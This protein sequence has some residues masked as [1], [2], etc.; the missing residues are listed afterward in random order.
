MVLLDMGVEYHCYASDITR[1]FPISG[2]FTPEQKDIWETVMDAKNACFAIIQPGVKW[3]NVHRAAE[4]SIVSSLI[5]RGYLRGDIDEMLQH[6]VAALFM[7]HGVGHLLGID[8]HD[9]GGY[10]RGTARIQLPGL[11]CL[12]TTRILQPGM[13]MTVEPGCYF[14]SCLLLPAFSDPKYAPYL[15][16]EKLRSLLS[17]GGVRIEDNIVIRE[18]GFENLSTGPQTAQEIEDIMAKARA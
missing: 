5:T 13:V 17:F 12:R 16:E 18:N 8:T 1:S 10:P 3:E 9:V 14:I 2:K 4:R 15:V 11:K 6:H 7:P